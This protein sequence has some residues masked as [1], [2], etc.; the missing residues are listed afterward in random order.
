MFLNYVRIIALNTDRCLAEKLI[1]YDI[2]K[3][4]EEDRLN[5]LQDESEDEKQF[6]NDFD[7][8]TVK[9][10]KRKGDHLLIIKNDNTIV[11]YNLFT[12]EIV[13]QTNLNSKI[14][15]TAIAI[16]NQR[17]TMLAVL[18]NQIIIDL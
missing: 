7:E 4:L 15:Q 2:E 5:C 14:D 10:F 9:L 18:N 6:T 8:R 1:K 11:L 17:T 12:D 3:A 13:Y 16:L